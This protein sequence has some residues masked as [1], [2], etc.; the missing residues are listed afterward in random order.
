MIKSTATACVA[1]PAAPD[2]SQID[3]FNDDVGPKIV[4]YIDK[5]QLILYYVTSGIT[6]PMGTAPPQSQRN[7]TMS[8]CE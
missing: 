7:G 2:K 6:C 1:A 4:Y 5:L 3:A 8:A